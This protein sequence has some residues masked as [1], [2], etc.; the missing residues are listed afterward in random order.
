MSPS[1]P[2]ID[3]NRQSGGGVIAGGYFTYEDGTVPQHDAMTFEETGEGCARVLYGALAF[4]LEED[5][6]TITAERPLTLTLKRG[7][8]DDHLPQVEDVADGRLTLSYHGVRYAVA[9]ERGHLLEPTK[10]ASDGGVIA[11]RFI[12]L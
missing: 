1:P 4:A 11:L 10:I 6:V 9:V 7:T 5:R 8:G 3:G 2:V 12:T